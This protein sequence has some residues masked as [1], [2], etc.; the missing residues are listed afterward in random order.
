MFSLVGAAVMRIRGPLT[1][2][3]GELSKEPC[4]RRQHSLAVEH[5]PKIPSSARCSRVQFAVASASQ[6]N[7]NDD[8]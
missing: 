2:Q 6:D 4:A 1:K 7:R 3:C 5:D 8:P